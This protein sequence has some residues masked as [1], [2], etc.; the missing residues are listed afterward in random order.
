MYTE[1]PLL[2]W[3]TDFLR[4]AAPCY[5]L[6]LSQWVRYSYALHVTWSPNKPWRSTSIFNLWFHGSQG[7]CP[8]KRHFGILRKTES[9]TLGISNLRNR[10]LRGFHSTTSRNSEESVSFLYTEFECYWSG[11]GL[12]RD[13]MRS[14]DQDLAN[15]AGSGPGFYKSGSE[16]PLR[17]L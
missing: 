3:L 7:G 17:L 6:G 5:L 13:S 14:V 12:D 11:S 4:L 1:E 16:T 10:N 9:Y 2:R 15:M 8:R